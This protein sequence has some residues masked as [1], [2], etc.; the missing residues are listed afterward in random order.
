QHIIREPCSF[1]PYRS[2][3]D[4]ALDLTFVSQSFD[5][6]QA[7]RIGPYRVVYPAEVDCQLSPL[8]FEEMWQKKTHFKKCQRI[9][10]RPH[11]LIPGIR[12]RRHQRRRGNVF[13]PAAGSG[14]AHSIYS[15]HEHTKELQCAGDLPSTEVA[16]GGVT[17]YVR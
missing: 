5:P 13:I 6:A 4:V 17:P 12:R 3:T 8:F 2:Q 1:T 11:H 16:R 15:A 7:I 10:A 14:A 9:L